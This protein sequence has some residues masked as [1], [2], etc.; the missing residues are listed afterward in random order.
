[1]VPRGRRASQRCPKNRPAAPRR[2]IEA[3]VWPKHGA[4][5]VEVHHRP[6]VAHDASTAIKG[7]HP[8]GAVQVDQRTGRVNAETT[9][10]DDPGVVAERADELAFGVEGE[11]RVMATAVGATCTGEEEAHQVI[12]TGADMPLCWKEIQDRADFGLLVVLSP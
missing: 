10:I 5:R 2:D 9:R 3:T 1:V 4:A 11:Q 7:E 6:R 12:L 8:L